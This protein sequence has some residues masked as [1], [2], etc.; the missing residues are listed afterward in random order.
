[1][2]GSLAGFALNKSHDAWLLYCEIPLSN[3]SLQRLTDKSTERDAVMQRVRLSEVAHKLE[4]THCPALERAAQLVAEL[5]PEGRD[6][7][8]THD[9]GQN[10]DTYRQ[11]ANSPGQQM[12]DKPNAERIRAYV[13]TRT[14]LSELEQ[15]AARHPQAIKQPPGEWSAQP[16]DVAATEAWLS[17]ARRQAG[18][19]H[20]VFACLD[21]DL[22]ILRDLNRE[23]ERLEASH[24][25]WVA[26]NNL[27]QSVASF[28][29][30]LISEDGG[31]VAN[32]LSYRYR[33]Q[34]IPLTAEEGETILDSQ[35][36]LAPLLKEESRI[37]QERGRRYSHSEADAR[38]AQVHRHI[39]AITAPVRTVIPAP[40]YTE[41]EQL[42]RQYR[43]EKPG[44]RA[45][46]RASAK[47]AECLDLPR[48][49]AWLEQEAP[50]H[51]RQVNERHAALYADRGVF[52]PRHVAGTWF[53][54]PDQP[55]HQQWLDELAEACLSA[56]CSR[57]Q[58]AEQ[59][60]NYVRASTDGVFRLIFQAWSP[61]LEAAV[62]NTNRFNEL[63]TALSLNRK[64]TR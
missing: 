31:E 20:G 62:N 37:N 47:V 49:N 28:I 52:L 45:D 61:S 14:W 32:L 17:Q 19:L 18:A 38:L 64:S 56:Q 15:A 16:W 5:I 44:N 53:V 43:T 41:G 3:S 7:A 9:Y 8:L 54:E 33:D 48:M 57:E 60:A 59:F 63:I 27:R 40:L 4:A 50:E 11:E 29:R 23:Q 26:D 42:V 24:E 22:G 34:N 46:G 55:D 58:G 25:A 35:R 30:S 36:K 6:Q 2:T 51:Y 1:T 12:I 39:A 21:D 10:S 13:H